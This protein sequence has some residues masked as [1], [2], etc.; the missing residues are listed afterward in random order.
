MTDNVLFVTLSVIMKNIVQLLKLIRTLGGKQG[1]VIRESDLSVI[2]DVKNRR[3]FFIKIKNL[4]SSGELKR[5]IRGVYILP[6]FKIEFL[7]Q[8]LCD[9][10]YISFERVLIETGAIGTSPENFIRAVKLGTPREYQGLDIKIRHLSIKEDLFF[11]YTITNGI[12]RACPE[13]ALLDVLYFYQK[14]EKFFFDIYSDIDLGVIDKKKFFV[15]LKLYK[16]KKF[17]KF[18]ENYLNEAA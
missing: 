11:G 1:G 9:N 8:I 3:Q 4:E 13:K 10:S 2:L 14:G 5:F 16:N 17:I 6:E 7:S 12:K 15:F 18:V